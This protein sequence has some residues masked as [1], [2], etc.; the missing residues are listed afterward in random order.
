MTWV[1]I[2]DKVKEKAYKMW[3]QNRMLIPNSE[4]WFYVGPEDS[5]TGQPPG[6]FK[7]TSM[8]EMW[9]DVPSGTNVFY[10]ENNGGTLAVAFT[11]LIEPSNYD[12]PTEHRNRNLT[13]PITITVP[14]GANFTV[15][16]LTD[17]TSVS[18][19]GGSNRGNFL[20]EENQTMAWLFREATEITLAPHSNFSLCSTLIAQSYTFTQLSPENQQLLQDIINKINLLDQESV[21]E[22]AF[23]TVEART[24]WDKWSPTDIQNYGSSNE[25]ISGIFQALADVNSSFIKDRDVIDVVI[26]LDLTY[27]DPI[28][29]RLTDTNA[30]IE[31]SFMY[32]DTYANNIP[33]LLHAHTNSDFIK[34][35]L[36][37]FKLDR[38]D[39]NNQW[40]Y[41]LKF[42]LDLNV[43][44]IASRARG[45]VH[46]FVMVKPASFIP[47]SST[48]FDVDLYNEGL[49]FTN[50]EDFQ[51]FLN[52]WNYNRVLNKLSFLGSLSLS[53][54]TNTTHTIYSINTDQEFRISY[55]DP[56]N[57]TN[58]DGK[59]EIII[60]TYKLADPIVVNSVLGL[61]FL[62]SNKELKQLS[63]DLVVISKDKATANQNGDLMYITIPLYYHKLLKFDYIKE[64]IFSNLSQ[65]NITDYTI[66]FIYS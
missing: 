26:E 39:I 66:D 15:Q 14:E 63:L 28:T 41:T 13:T 22:A 40:R 11:E 25:V 24:Y 50:D 54:T 16:S 5:I 17:R 7:L 10:A 29:S 32:R 61:N 45:D 60:P 34:E 48:E 58:N 62:T 53:T 56:F 52:Q 36:L 6:A 1:K 12:I 4:V 55:H 57:P 8:Q 49:I 35:H 59:L 42:D 47:V 46:Y 2:T 21:K 64:H 20:L 27:T 31:L 33:T 44:K 23:K 30:F 37:Q 9:R 19:G 18:I 51:K 43:S 3:I 65:A 38:D